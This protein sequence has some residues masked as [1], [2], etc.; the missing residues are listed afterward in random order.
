MSTKTFEKQCHNRHALSINP[1]VILLGSFARLKL[2]PIRN[3]L[4][5]ANEGNSAAGAQG[6]DTN[7]RKQAETEKKTKRKQGHL[8][9]SFLVGTVRLTATALSICSIKSKLA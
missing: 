1:A 7:K 2:V 5:R 6:N 8:I 9:T 3:L 4:E